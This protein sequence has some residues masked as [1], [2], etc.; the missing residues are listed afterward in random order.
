L[1][2]DF[3]NNDYRKRERIFGITI[4]FS[5]L[6]FLCLSFFL[7]FILK[8][9]AESYEVLGENLKY[10]IIYSALA[11]VLIVIIFAIRKLY[12]FRNLYKG[13]GE[14][15]GVAS[16]VLISIF[17]IMMLN[18]S[19][20]R[21]GYQLSRVWIIYSIFI[22]IVFVIIGRTIVKRLFFRYLSKK[23][24]KTNVAIIGINE[25]SK[26]IAHT[27]NKS[28]IERINVAGFIDDKYKKEDSGEAVSSGDMKILGALDGL[29]AII[30]KYNIHRIIISSTEL[31]YFDIMTL[32]DRITDSAI[33]VQMSPSLFEFSVSRMKMFDYMGIPL[34]Q[35]QKVELK[36]FDKV[37]KS[38]IDYTIGVILFVIFILMY[39]VV[40][41]L[42]KLDSKGPVLYK[43]Q[44]YGKDFKIINVYKFRTMRAGADKE[45]EYI[46]HMYDRKS[47]FKM[48]NDPRVTRV[49]RILRETSI[50]ELPQVINVFKGEL[51]VIGPRALAIEEGNQL[52]EWEKK[53]MQVKQGIT[54]LWQVSGRSDISYEE[55]IKLDLYYIQNWSIWLEFKI[56]ILTI[57][58]IFSGSGAY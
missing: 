2:R 45:E 6:I 25:E 52:E 47:D 57:V 28:T 34:I 1:D 43:Q 3:L 38:I 32:M 40:G 27:L 23:G 16:S 33:E 56:I 13:M 5:D 15:E 19:F 8:F 9:R 53:R 49:G 48:K 22:P 50:D 54:G 41:I 36:T 26:R 10:Y 42:I 30:K 29:E 58:R 20:N 24:V 17:L 35:I 7:S 37:L 14:N 31:K 51:S 39:P 4:F 21:G 55:R 12:S 46:K 44:R 18:Y 11:I